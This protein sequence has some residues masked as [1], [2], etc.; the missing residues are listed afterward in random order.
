MKAPNAVKRAVTII[1]LSTLSLL[2]PPCPYSP[3]YPRH[4]ALSRA[5]MLRARRSASAWVRASTWSWA[6]ASSAWASEGLAPGA[7]FG[8][9]RIAGASARARRGFAGRLSTSRR[10]TRWLFRE[11]MNGGRDGPRSF[12]RQRGPLWIVE[13]GV[14][15][16]RACGW[17]GRATWPLTT[18]PRARA[19]HSEPQATSGTRTAHT[20]T[21]PSA[22]PAAAT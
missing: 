3:Y 7:R 2:S 8:R 17:A 14:S 10:T 15:N 1:V 21:R 6:A 13:R 22:I 5:R 19:P 4:A 18:C 12:D 20:A 16:E 11:Y 9:L